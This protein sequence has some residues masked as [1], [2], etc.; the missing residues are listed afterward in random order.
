[1]WKIP[2]IALIS[3]VCWKLMPASE[4]LQDDER[5]SKKPE[6]VGTW[7][8]TSAMSNGKEYE[9]MKGNTFIFEEDGSY[10]HTRKAG[11][12][13]KGTFKTSPKGDISLI[14]MESWED[15][16]EVGGAGP[17]LGIYKSEADK[18]KTRV[19]S[20]CIRTGGGLPRPDDFKSTK[21]SHRL[22]IN[23]QQVQEE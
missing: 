13:V 2:C 14:A 22:L 11:L 4:L 19:L 18:D 9:S 21:G 10:V 5:E 15:K 7:I 20:I 16:P 6:I 23:L 8:V 17:R 1:M 3:I 12:Q